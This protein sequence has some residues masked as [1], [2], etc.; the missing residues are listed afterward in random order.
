MNKKY[1]ILVAEVMIYAV[2]VPYKLAYNSTPQTVFFVSPDLS[3][4]FLNI[5]TRFKLI[6]IKIFHFY[7]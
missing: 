7:F 3:Q 5:Y 1:L 4:Y 6:I 2:V